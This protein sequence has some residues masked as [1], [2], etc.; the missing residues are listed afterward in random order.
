METQNEKGSNLFTLDEAKAAGI[1]FS[2]P[3]ESC[4]PHCGEA[5]E[6]IG[7]MGFGNRFTWIGTRECECEGAEIERAEIEAAK[8]RQAEADRRAEF[9]RSGVKPRFL[10]AKVDNAEAA[11]YLDSFELARGVGLYIH[12]PSRAG[13]TYCASAMAKAFIS[14][15]YSVILT[16]SLEMLDTIKES[17]DGN[18]KLGPSRFSGCDVLIIDDIGKENAN[19]WV[20]TTLFQVIN[21][22]YES[23][24]PT[25]V[26]S[27]YSPYELT[28]RM[29][30]SGERESAT[31]IVERLKETCQLFTLPPRR[32]VH[33]MNKQLSGA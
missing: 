22:R 29:S 11:R 28:S 16:T 20:M 15:G 13:K 33:L 9:A 2:D 18:S 30:R 25:I 32:N 3:K 4:C 1:E 12:G 31:A 21:S 7:L 24:R 27:Q 10:D 5:L 23:M 14:A 26:T 6:P 8:Q 19:A 17:F